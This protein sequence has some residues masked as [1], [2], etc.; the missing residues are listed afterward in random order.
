M[1]GFEPS[2]LSIGLMIDWI[3]TELRGGKMKVNI[4]YWI[5]TQLRAD[6]GI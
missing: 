5:I 3:V 4:E 6:F 2:I 1:P